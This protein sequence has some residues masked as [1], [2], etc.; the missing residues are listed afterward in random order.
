MNTRKKKIV[1][2]IVFICLALISLEFV[3][4]VCRMAFNNTC[5]EMEEQYIS[6]QIDEEIDS[7]ENS[8][9]FGKNLSNYYGM[10]KVL[11]SIE[12]ISEGNLKVIVSDTEGT[13]KY[14][15]FEESDE[16]IKDLAFFYSDDYRQ[17]F[18]STEDRGRKIDFGKK[19]S[20]VYPV[21]KGEDQLQGYVVVI[22][23][24]NS[25]IDGSR[26][27]DVRSVIIIITAV[28]A[29]LLIIVFIVLR[30]RIKGKAEKVIPVVILMI[31]ILTFI[32]YLFSVYRDKYNQLIT[33]KT[34]ALAEAFGEKTDAVV[35]KGL[36][37]D[38]LYKLDDYFNEKQ[39]E[40]E[41]IDT[42]E[43]VDGGYTVDK[44]DI[45][46]VY[47]P[48]ASQRAAIKAVISMDYI[49]NKIWLMTLTFGAVFVVCLMTAYELT[50]FVEVASARF[51]SDFN[52]VT[53]E[54]NEGLSAQI[55]VLS[56]L[57]FTAIYICLPYAAVIMRKWDVSVFGLSKSVSASLPLTI[58]L[59]CVLLASTV[60]QRLFNT[61]KLNRMMIFVF[62]FL[63]LGN[64][65]CTV[66]SSPYTLIALR[67]LCGIGF[68]FLKY[69]LNSIVAAASNDDNF[70]ANC[71]MMNA[72]LLGG[73][74]VGASLGSIF[75]QAMGYQSN[76]LFTAV[77]FGFILLWV[78]PTMPWKVIAKGHE[79]APSTEKTAV[80]KNKSNILKNPR[81]F[82]TLLFGCIPLNIGLMYVVAFV[83]SYMSNAGHSA[84]VTSYVYL[85][86]GLAGIYIGML[87]LR[88]LKKKSLF[89]SASI[90][91]FLAAGGML[92][93]LVNNSIAIIMISAGV[94]GLFDGFGTPSITSYFTSL[95]P[96]KSE[97]AG[98]M[99]TFNIVGSAVQIACPTLYNLL[100]QPDGKVT[101]L[102]IFGIAYIV[103]A[104]LFVI[105]CRPDKK[106]QSA[107]A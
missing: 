22:Y 95:T 34:V 90:A 12:S 41:S 47:V 60:I 72:G 71:G 52:T 48:V 49:K 97:V 53:E 56:F 29:I 9:N 70:S 85:V 68:A 16:N 27:G 2:T 99:T 87:I 104:V 102:M 42:L 67:A 100:I 83:P 19:S 57:A 7:I 103:V 6:I 93:L 74:T 75:A 101:N 36:S 1:T 55:R 78:I 18:L 33:E 37:V 50:H 88:F 61:T 65:A 98:M 31:A 66:V 26:L 73:I 69:W 8:I 64:I 43:I 44:N 40:I 15:S 32:L 10:D 14:L 94:L 59:L 76:Y 86:N 45:Y 81:Q 13:P 51:S 30:D 4:W 23:D 3:D 25:L 80:E 20:L 91:L 28:I 105:M 106:K 35:R 21:T 89:V 79:S 17:K 46:T 58:E 92:I 107:E 39:E 11:D 54:Q 24:A 96:K 84:V 63:I 5:I 38:Q 62:P 77:I 82:L